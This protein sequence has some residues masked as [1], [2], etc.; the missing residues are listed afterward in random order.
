MAKYKTQNLFDMTPE[1]DIAQ[2]GSCGHI[3]RVAFDSAVDNEFDYAVSDEFW[4]ILPGQRVQV[5]D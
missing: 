5:F 4:P 1:D 3:I 2:Q